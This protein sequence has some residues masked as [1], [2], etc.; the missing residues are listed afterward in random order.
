[1]RF[2]HFIQATSDWCTKYLRQVAQGQRDGSLMLNGNEILYPN[3]LLVTNCKGYYVA[4]LIGA[5]EHFDRLR[6]KKHEEKSIYR[7]F[8]Q[9]NDSEPESA[10]S[11]NSSCNSFAFV[12]LAQGADFQAI[13]NRFPQIELYNSPRINRIGGH[14][15]VFS[16]G[17]NFTSFS[18]HNS[19]LINKK[20]DVYRCKNILSAYVVK[21]AISSDELIELFN[22]TISQNL[23]INIHPV[24]RDKKKIIIAGQLQSMYLFPSLRETT[25]GQF[26][27]L[28]PE[29]VKKAFKTEHFVYEPYLKWVEH[30]GTCED[31]AINPDLMIKRKDGYYDIYDLKTSLL[32][33][34]NLTKGKRKRRRF[35]DYVEEGIAQLANYREY[36]RYDRNAKFAEERYGIFVDNPQLVL[37]VGSFE[38]AKID[39]INQA[40]R[41]YEGISVIDY[42]TLCQLFL[43]KSQQKDAGSH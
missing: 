9:F 25:I 4:E 7:Y 39:E 26:I 33:K 24:H 5:V 40:C 28:H 8:S 41:R 13:T 21:S 22:W 17:E 38:N 27:N 31:Q 42:D 23:A 16:F 43:G 15:S 30:D 34:D 18:I 32:T 12:C 19:I 35:I 3:I 20:E 36:F 10:F 11:L 29:I 1:M 14:G 6:I 37:V 2:K